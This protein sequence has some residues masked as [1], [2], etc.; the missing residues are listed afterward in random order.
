MNRPQAR[1]DRDYTQSELLTNL[2]IRLCVHICR[3]K[4]HFMLQIR[5]YAHRQAVKVQSKFSLLEMRWC[6]DSGD[7]EIRRPSSDLAHVK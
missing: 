5:R 3:P 4:E 1:I 6:L 7:Q 2:M